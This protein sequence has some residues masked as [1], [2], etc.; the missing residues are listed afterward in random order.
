MCEWVKVTTTRC[1]CRGHSCRKSD[2]RLQCPYSRKWP[3]S[4]QETF[5]QT[6]TLRPQPAVCSLDNLCFTLGSSDS[7]WWSPPTDTGTGPITDM[8]PSPLSSSL[9]DHL[10]QLLVPH[11][12]LTIVRY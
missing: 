1:D 2:T 9:T 12:D 6:Q 8:A 3:A 7:I 10:G 4:C 5:L 11:S